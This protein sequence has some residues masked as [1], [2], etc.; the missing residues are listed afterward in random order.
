[1]IESENDRRA[2][3]RDAGEFVTFSGRSVPCLFKD[4]FQPV[5][6]GDARVS[7]RVITAKCSTIDVKAVRRH[8][9]VSV[10]GT[11]YTVENVEPSDSGM[12]M[13]MLSVVD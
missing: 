2:I 7:A 5:D 10:R 4:G 6:V 11:T 13:L 3:L 9:R 1:M 12:T 8:S